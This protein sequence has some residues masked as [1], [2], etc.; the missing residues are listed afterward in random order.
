MDMRARA[1]IVIGTVSLLAMG[2]PTA[3]GQTDPFGMAGSQEVL[4]VVGQVAAPQQDGMILRFAWRGHTES[5]FH[6]PQFG[7]AAVGEVERLVVSG[8]ALYLL[9]SDGSHWRHTSSGQQVVDTFPGHHQPMAWAAST[10]EDTLIA[11]VAGS[12]FAQLHAG[13]SAGASPPAT[14]PVENAEAVVSK[15][16]FAETLGQRPDAA[17]LTRYERGSWQPAEDRLIPTWF[18]GV[19]GDDGNR[20]VWLTAERDAVH[21]LYRL[22]PGSEVMHAVRRNSAWS[23]PISTGVS[24][25]IP[26][27]GAMV[28]NKRLLFVHTV[29]TSDPD[30]AHLHIR[31]HDGQAWQAGPILNQDGRNQTFDPENLAVSWFGQN[32]AVAE[33]SGPEAIKVTLWRPDTGELLAGDEQIARLI[34][35]PRPGA[36]EGLAHWLFIATMAL[37]L[38]AGMRRRRANRPRPDDS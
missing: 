18:D 15:S 20:Q 2:L 31:H 35:A 6:P 11:V 26:T 9:Y 1:R 8:T 24:T 3:R 17:G 30:S 12:V 16:T 19:G 28:V 25:P 14:A 22:E 36:G 32:I 21:L 5:T 29:P 38:L 27:G 7:D 37:I 34:P 4:W 23:E 10:R 13:H 33:R